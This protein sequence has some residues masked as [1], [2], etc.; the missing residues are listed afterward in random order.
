MNDHPYH[1]KVCRHCDVY[2]KYCPCEVPDIKPGLGLTFGKVMA[3]LI[4]AGI[5]IGGLAALQFFF[6]MLMIP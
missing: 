2:A 5:V 6:T 3:I 4:V 1:E